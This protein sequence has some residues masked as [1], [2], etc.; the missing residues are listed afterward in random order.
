MWADCRW[1]IATTL[2]RSSVTWGE[3]AFSPPACTLSKT[4]TCVSP[5]GFPGL[6]DVRGRILLLRCRDQRLER[7]HGHS[8]RSAG[9]TVDISSID[10]NYF[11]ARVEDRSAAASVCGRSVVNQLVANHVAQ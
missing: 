6:T 10:S 9:K 7:I 5:A 11:S 8:K 2:A 1:W 3:K 4:S